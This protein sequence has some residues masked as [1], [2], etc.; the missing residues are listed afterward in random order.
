MLSRTPP[1]ICRLLQLFVISW[2]QITCWRSRSRPGLYALSGRH[3][4]QCISSDLTS[5]IY[6]HSITLN[7][8]PSQ[9]PTHQLHQFCLSFQIKSVTRKMLNTGSNLLLF[10]TCEMFHLG[11][12]FVS[13]VSKHNMLTRTHSWFQLVPVGW[14]FSAYGSQSQHARWEAA[15]LQSTHSS[16]QLRPVV[17]RSLTTIQVC[18]DEMQRA[19]ACLVVHAPLVT[20][21]TVTKRNTSGG[22][23]VKTKAVPWTAS[24]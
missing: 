18:W 15:V 21:V 24:S 23:T 22:R 6:H 20:L 10:C 9:K 16:Q 3:S 5:K 12:L 2:K 7:Q 8:S 14:M 4:W 19:D 17:G 11:C 13:E 1:L